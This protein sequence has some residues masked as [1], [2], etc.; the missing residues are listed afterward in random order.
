MNHMQFSQQIKSQDKINS[1]MLST[2]L[3]DALSPYEYRYQRYNHKYALALIYFNTHSFENDLLSL[4][5]RPSDKYL[6]ISE[7]MKAIIFDNIS[8][9][10]AIKALTNQIIRIE[11]YS[12]DTTIYSCSI[13]RSEHSD[14]T[15]LVKKASILLQHAIQYDIKNTAIDSS[16]LEYFYSH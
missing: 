5:L 14:T 11:A 9:S 3:N 7:Q 10:A 6:T 8:E 16:Y 2:T 12:F 13:H 1:N 4:S 15:G